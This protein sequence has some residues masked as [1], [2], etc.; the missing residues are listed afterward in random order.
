M[1]GE[2]ETTWGF[3]SGAISDKTGNVFS[4]PAFHDHAERT[5][6]APDTETG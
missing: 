3:I 6:H 4:W 1:T 2:Y 5:D